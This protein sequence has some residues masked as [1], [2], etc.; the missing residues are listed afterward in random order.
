MAEGIVLRAAAGL[1]CAGG[2]QGRRRGPRLAGLGLIFS[3]EEAGGAPSPCGRVSGSG[4]GE[5]R[6]AR[7]AS[8]A[9][10]LGRWEARAQERVHLLL[11]SGLGAES[12]SV[13]IITRKHT[14]E[15]NNVMF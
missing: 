3:A 15:E 13:A 10:R 4:T 6:G 11:A 2:A 1:R 9:G 12:R 14:L 8:G 5:A 7:W